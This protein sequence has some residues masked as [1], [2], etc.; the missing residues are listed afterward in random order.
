MVAILLVFAVL[1]TA[2]SA[3]L[4]YWQVIAAAELAPNAIQSMTPVRAALPARADILDRDG[5]VLA[6]TASFDSL[7]AHPSDIEPEDVELILDTLEPIL[8]LDASEREAYAEK[9]QSGK[10]WT[11]LEARVTHKQ[12][13]AIALA[14]D[15][16]DLPGITLDPKDV[17]VY[18]RKGGASD[19]TLASHVLGF[20]RADGRGGEGVERQYDE[21]LTTPETEG[22]DLATI[23]G[24]PDGLEGL[25]PEPLRLTLDAGLQRQVEKELNTAYL[26][27]RAKSASAIVM[28][29]HTGAILA[30]ASVPAYDGNEYAR[31]A[32]DDIGRL[33]NRVISDQYEPGSVMKIFTATAALDLGLVTPNTVISD[34]RKLEFYK[35]QVQNADH[36]SLGP[37]KVKDVIARSRNV[38]TA[39]IAMKLAP[40]S[41]QRAADRLYG[42]WKKVGMAA[43]TEVDI[44]NETQGRWFDPEQKLWAPVDLANRAFGQGVSVTLLQLARGISTLVNGGFVVQPHIAA[45]GDAARAPK[46]RVVKAKVAR[47]AKDILVHVTGSVPWYAKGS[48]IPGYTIGGK[49]GTAQIWDV[50]KARWKEKRFNHSFIGFAGGRQQEIVIAVRLEEPV[51][52]M[53]EQGVIPLRIESY[54]LFQMIARASIKHL[55]MKKSKDP[56]AGRPLPGTDAARALGGSSYKAALQ[57]AKAKSRAKGQSTE[58]RKQSAENGRKAQGDKVKSERKA[59]R[60]RDAGTSA[61]KRGKPD[62]ATRGLGT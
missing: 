53:I 43:R 35:Y 47:Q 21:R 58:D 4:G 39:K 13:A 44:A 37:L 7:D 19:S 2:A 33:R 29:P 16:G 14:Q 11:N 30:I 52:D 27:N 24:L 56:L 62:R 49:T 22:L 17:R 12:S 25:D 40:K 10:L 23:E 32:A 55:D 1:G 15:K 51:P 50:D 5:V 36:G 41:V 8:R 31:I 18:P 28:D 60:G 9:I 46:E 48:L 54:E 38:A 45:D 6:Q 42:F 59:E 26:V 20:V 57:K 61:Q 34:Q 3:R